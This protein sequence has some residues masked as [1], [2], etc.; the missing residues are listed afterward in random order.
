MV[1]HILQSRRVLQSWHLG[2][3]TMGQDY[4]QIVT[5]LKSQNA[6]KTLSLV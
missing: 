1:A 5:I 6:E 3:Q 2:S 4:Q